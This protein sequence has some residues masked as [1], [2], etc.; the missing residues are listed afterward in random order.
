MQKHIHVSANQS[1][2]LPH[3]IFFQFMKL[4][5]SQKDR[6]F[7]KLRPAHYNSLSFIRFNRNFLYDEKVFQTTLPVRIRNEN[8]LF[9]LQLTTTI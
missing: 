8:S 6:F 4:S 3:I 2:Q 7:Y 9:L 5:F 1:S